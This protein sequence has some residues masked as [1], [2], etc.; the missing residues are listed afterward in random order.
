MQDNNL[1]GVD[2]TINK[3]VRKRVDEPC[4]TYIIR[5]F[6][7][8]VYPYSSRSYVPVTGSELGSARG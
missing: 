8:V 4:R 7:I 6:L 3:Y 5:V 1:V 2:T